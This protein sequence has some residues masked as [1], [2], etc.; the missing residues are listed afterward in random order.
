MQDEAAA[1]AIANNPTND[2]IN[3]TLLYRGGHSGV[4]RFKRP[5]PGIH[6]PRP[7]VMDSG[8]AG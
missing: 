2:A 7:V 8:L 5:E 4:G 6:N 3:S 1:S